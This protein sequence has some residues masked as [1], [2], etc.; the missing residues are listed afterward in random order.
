MSE[1]DDRSPPSGV[2]A[3]LGLGR[4]GSVTRGLL[5]AGAGGTRRIGRGARRL[6]NSRTVRSANRFA[7][8][9]VQTGRRAGGRLSTRS[10]LG[11]GLAAAV[12]ISAGSMSASQSIKQQQC[13]DQCVALGPGGTAP[14]VEDGEEPVPTCAATETACDDYCADECRKLH[15]ASFADNVANVVAGAAIYA[16]VVAMQGIFG[17][18]AHYTIDVMTL[19]VLTVV[20][21]VVHRV[22]GAFLWI[23]RLGTYPYAFVARVLVVLYLLVSFYK[24]ALAERREDLRDRFAD[25]EG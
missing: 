19:T 12:G 15:P 7:R 23:T 25:D 10:R 20:G 16:C 14:P 1:E 18:S 4:L 21:A 8:G 9:T 22:V 13:V 3:K 2:S 5:R 11:L 24:H 6:G 17:W